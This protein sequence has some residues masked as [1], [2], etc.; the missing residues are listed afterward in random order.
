M[1]VRDEYDLLIEEKGLPAFEELKQEAASAYAGLPTEFTNNLTEANY[2]KLFMYYRYLVSSILNEKSN[3]KMVDDFLVNNGL[4]AKVA[5][6]DFYQKYDFMGLKFFYLRSFAHIERLSE[7]QI[8]LLERCLENGREEDIDEAIKMVESTYKNI[9]SIS[10]EAPKYQYEMYP[11]I[12]GDGLV[13][14]DVCIL[15]LRRE[16][17]YDEDGMIADW[18]QEEARFNM[19]DQ[20]KYL[21]EDKLVEFWDMKTVVFLEEM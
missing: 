20:V 3:L 9:L 15:G 21:L 17:L 11:S 12:H 13:E 7:Q 18:K 4:S 16:V 2:G 10:P 1:N 8:A 19:L 5:E 14:G 6:D